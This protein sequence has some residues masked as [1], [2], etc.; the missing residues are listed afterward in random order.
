[1]LNPHDHRTADRYPA[2]V[3]SPPEPPLVFGAPLIE[4]A[5]IEEVVRTLRSGWLGTGPKTLQFE[6]EFAEYVGTRFAVATNSGTAALHLSLLGL[7]VGRGDEV[8]TT[9]LTFVATANVIEHCGARPVFVDVDPSTGNISPEAVAAAIS[10]R[11]RAILPVHYLGALADIEGIRRIAG[12]IPIVIDAAH[13]VEGRHLRNGGSSAWGGRS[14]CYSF[15]VTKNVV[16]GEGGMLVT[17]DEDL[18]KFARVA[19][20]HGL[21]N[22]AYTRYS[23]AGYREYEL[24]LPGFKYNMTDMQASLG[25]HQLRR[26]DRS[27]ATRSQLWG[28]YNERLLDVRG[29]DIPGVALDHRRPDH[30]RHLYTFWADWKRL[31]LSRRRLVSALQMRGVGTGWHFRA[32]HLQRFYRERYGYQEGAFGVAESIADRTVSLP[33]SAALVPHSID[34]ATRAL[35]EALDDASA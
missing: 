21:D 28:R 31:G 14:A 2:L 22:D 3:D 24:L 32:V 15:Y 13:A 10:P 19:A 8:I 7:G 9:P 26:I 18:A 35:L 34:R 29:I 33:L 30:A 25:L 11:T 6:A 5:E 4:E 1:M 20:L 27:Q 23:A 17:D 12:D 16:T